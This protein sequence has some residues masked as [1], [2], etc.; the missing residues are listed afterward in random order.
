MA[1]VRALPRTR[2]RKGAFSRATAGTEPGR[3]APTG[4]ASRRPPAAINPAAMP[5]KDTPAPP[6]ATSGTETPLVPARSVPTAA[7]AIVPPRSR[8]RTGVV[9]ND[10]AR[11][12]H[13]HRPLLIADI[14]ADL[15][16][17]GV[18]FQPVNHPIDRRTVYV[19]AGQRH[20]DSR[21]HLR[22]NPLLERLQPLT[23]ILRLGDFGDF[24]RQAKSII[25]P[26]CGL[27]RGQPS[28][29]AQG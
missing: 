11:Q 4:L 20:P 16:I 5:A 22:A 10:S 24:I 15:E 1:S 28:V 25:R 14:L 27:A 29:L 17:L 18:E 7:V 2:T 23:G 13:G 9:G 12:H 3:Y 8:A 6:A 19:P 21:L 26:T